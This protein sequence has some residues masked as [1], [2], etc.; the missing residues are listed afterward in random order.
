MLL[1]SC[2]TVQSD[3]DATIDSQAFVAYLQPFPSYPEIVVTNELDKVV[4]DQDDALLLAG[5]IQEVY[6]YYNVYLKETFIPTIENLS[7]VSNAGIK[8]EIV[9]AP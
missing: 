4:I 3:Y 2:R 6:D 1:T 5:W 9:P 7:S 8:V